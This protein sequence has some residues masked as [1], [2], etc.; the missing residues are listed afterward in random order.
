MITKPREL[1]L[2][3]QTEQ[4]LATE[5]NEAGLNWTDKAT[6]RSPRRS[7]V[8]WRKSRPARTWNFTAALSPTIRPGLYTETN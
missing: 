2:L 4:V 8:W 6:A 1:I 7:E 3:T 5:V